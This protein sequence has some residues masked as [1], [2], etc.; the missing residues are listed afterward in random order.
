MLRAELLEFAHCIRDKRA[1]PVDIE[2]VLHG[3]AVF[4]TCVQSAKTGGIAK[5][6][7]V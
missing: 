4:D 3:M 5:V 2:G 7:A 6:S 1:Y